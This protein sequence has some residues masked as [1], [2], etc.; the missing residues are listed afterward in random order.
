MPSTHGPGLATAELLQIATATALNSA[1]IMARSLQL[2]SRS[3]EIAQRVARACER[4]S[5]VRAELQRTT[6]RPA[7]LATK[8]RPTTPADRQA[9][10]PL[11]PPRLLELAEEFRCLARGATTPESRSAF[12]DLVFRYTALAAGYD[13]A[14]VGSRMLH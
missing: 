1:R 8:L 5:S 10:L 14:R 11:T 13:N 3:A 6:L 12:E 4:A 7:N 2:I 9:S